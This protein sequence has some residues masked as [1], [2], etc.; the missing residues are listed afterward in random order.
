MS[1]HEYVVTLRV[2]TLDQA[3]ELRERAIEALGPGLIGATIRR[4]RQLP[5]T[6]AMKW[7]WMELVR[8][9]VRA[10]GQ[11]VVQLVWL[12]EGMFDIHQLRRAKK[13]LGLETYRRS[14]GGEWWW[15]LLEDG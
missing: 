15:R 1:A 8:P 6:E 4:V 5:D 10:E 7:L 2:L 13:R 12:A 3:H 11:P 14:F 9:E